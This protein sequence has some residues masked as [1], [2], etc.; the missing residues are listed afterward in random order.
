MSL[1]ILTPT[2]LVLPESKTITISGA[3][4]TFFLSGSYVYLWADSH[5]WV[6]SGCIVK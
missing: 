3:H 1:D 4:G 5:L 2:A 6:L